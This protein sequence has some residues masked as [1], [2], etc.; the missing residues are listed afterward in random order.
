LAAASIIFFF[1]VPAANKPTEASLKEKLLQMDIPG[2]LMISASIVCFL[3][4]LQWGGAVKGWSSSD[5]VGTLV[6]CVVLFA[7]FLIIEYYQGERA[8]LLRSVLRNRT[9]AHGCA[10]SFL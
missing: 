7:A 9:I 3:L 4:A 2:F 6:G 5:V 10:F 8:L 1:R